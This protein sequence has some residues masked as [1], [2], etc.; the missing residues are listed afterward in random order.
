MIA[1]NGGS[2]DDKSRI[3]AIIWFNY[4]N[5]NV[6]NEKL[7]QKIKKLSFTNNKLSYYGIFK[8]FSGEKSLR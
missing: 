6:N 2:I 3:F 7:Y 8:F 5:Y 1:F 4:V